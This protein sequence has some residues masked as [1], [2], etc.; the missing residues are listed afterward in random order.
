MTKSGIAELRRLLQQPD[1][2]L[3]DGLVS[4]QFSEDTFNRICTWKETPYSEGAMLYLRPDELR[5]FLTFVLY[6]ETDK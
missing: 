1:D 2:R 5:M 3:A 6:A 4:Y